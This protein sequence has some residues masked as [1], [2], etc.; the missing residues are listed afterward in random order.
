[1][2]H[3]TF[4][5]PASYK[6]WTWGLIVAGL[7]AVLYGFIM[8]HPFT[9]PVHGEGAHGAA[10]H[11]SVASTRF[12]AVLLQNS[13]YWL[14]TVNASMFFICVTTLAMGGWQVAL[15][16]VP[17]AISSVVP[18]LGLITFVILLAIVYGGRT[19]IYHWLDASLYDKSSEHFDKILN[20]KKG[21]LNP[22]FFIVWSALSIGLWSLLGAKLRSLS[23]KSDETGPMDIVQAKKWIDTNFTYASY[24]VVFFGLTVAS[25]V[26]W[27]WLMSIDAH[28][29]STMYSWYTFAS[30]FVSGLSLMAIFIIF[31]KNRGQL[32]YVTEEHLHDVGKFM[33]AF[34]V[35][36]TYLWFS[37][38]MLIWYSNQPEETRYFVA[39]LGTATQAGPYK[40]IFF[41]N[42]IVNFLAP[43]LILMRKGS[44]RNWTVVTFVG[45]LII[46]GHWIDFY[47]MVMPGT[48]HENAELM[49]FE[50]GVA[51]LFIGIIMWGVGRFFT[52]HSLIAKNHPFLKESM[53]HHT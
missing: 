19:D 6:K 10:G 47:Q 7:L 29:Y 40:G 26:P 14:L 21:F 12:W 36:W 39:R 31:L 28:W 48:L 27:L 20:G 11:E 18:I 17:E 44:K 42:L 22:T 53:I 16:R 41:F 5:L 51:C 45:V 37:Q 25:T 33:F 52:K 23:L 8:Y 35:F 50:F 9:H 13:V 15:R 4:Q 38:Y 32:E 1:M 30:T 24:Y 34:S 49:P 43:L 46:F 3:N 2:N